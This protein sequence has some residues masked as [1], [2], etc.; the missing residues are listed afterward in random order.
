MSRETDLAW[1]A[2]IIDGEG[3][4]G[5]YLSHTNTGDCYVLKLVVVNTNL[6]I[7]VPVTGGVIVAIATV[8]VTNVRNV[9]GAIVAALAIVT[10]RGDLSL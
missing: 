3:H 6:S 9:V 10:G 5:L 4:I 8:P 7:T 2:G 1:A